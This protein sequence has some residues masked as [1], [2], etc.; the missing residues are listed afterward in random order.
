MLGES[1]AIRS[2]FCEFS[3][4]VVDLSVDAKTRRDHIE[5]RVRS[6]REVG[7][8][9]L[10]ADFDVSEMTIRRDVEALETLGVVRRVVG[11]AIALKGRD[12]EQPFA[13]RVTE[14]A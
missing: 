8:A 14:A 6:E 2:L 13:T 9:E 4:H 12:R 10:A 11:G 5:Q 3:T 7:Y 1:P